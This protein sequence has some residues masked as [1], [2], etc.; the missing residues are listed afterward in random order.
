MIF[1]SKKENKSNNSR[2]KRAV[3]NHFIR[4][5][6]R[7]KRA[8]EKRIFGISINWFYILGIALVYFIYTFSEGL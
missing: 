2:A 6:E 5:D 7:R 4:S 1:L 3:E 8:T